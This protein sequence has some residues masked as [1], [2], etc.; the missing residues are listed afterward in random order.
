LSEAL[1]FLLLPEEKYDLVLQYKLP[2]F[3]SVLFIAC[4]G[5]Q[6]RLYPVTHP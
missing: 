4:W 6:K 5:A 1:L 2:C 3:T